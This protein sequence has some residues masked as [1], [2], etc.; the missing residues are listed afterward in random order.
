MR[1]GAGVGI[2]A[3]YQTS[4][5]GSLMI[6]ADQPNKEVFFPVADSLCCV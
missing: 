1:A 6:C 2:S 3:P 4:H 5:A